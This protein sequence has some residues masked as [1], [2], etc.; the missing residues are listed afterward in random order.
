[1]NVRRTSL[2]SGCFL[3][4][5]AVPLVAQHAPVKDGWTITVN[6]TRG[7]VRAVTISPSVT[8][9]TTEVLAG[10]TNG[11]DNAYLMFT[12]LPAR[13]RG[14]GMSVLPDDHLILVLEGKLNIQ[15]GT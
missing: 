7:P 15:I 9:A 11:S 12:R 13:G 1:M 10:P 5:M 8:A 6:E 4:V 3:V 2:I 14:P